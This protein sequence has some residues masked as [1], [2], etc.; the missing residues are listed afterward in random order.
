MPV[1]AVSFTK[2]QSLF[3]NTRSRDI[4]W[5][6]CRTGFDSDGL[7]AAKVATNKSLLDYWLCNF[8]R[9]CLLNYGYQIRFYS[10]WLFRNK[11]G[12]YDLIAAAEAKAGVMN[13][14]LPGEKGV[15]ALVKVYDNGITDSLKVND[16]IDVFGVVSSDPALSLMGDG[17]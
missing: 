6:R 7:T 1:E 5:A 2:T 8:Y 12:C 15:A 3:Y 4:R 17:E 9:S 13:F 10:I 16:V 14:P 11:Y